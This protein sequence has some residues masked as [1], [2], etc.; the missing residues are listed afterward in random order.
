MRS[1]SKRCDRYKKNN[2]AA[3][4]GG[5]QAPVN[6]LLTGWLLLGYFL[7]SPGVSPGL[8]PDLPR[9]VIRPALSET[10][11]RKNAM[12]AVIYA[13]LNPVKTLRQIVGDRCVLRLLILVALLTA[14]CL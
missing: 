7:C 11:A 10:G 3:R 5:I 9:I 13:Q 14:T 1:E 8:F 12:K 2:G 4:S 6:H